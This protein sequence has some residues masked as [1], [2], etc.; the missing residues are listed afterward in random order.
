[1]ETE[2]G[3]ELN[4]IREARCLRLEGMAII[5][6]FSVNRLSKI[7]NGKREIPPGMTDMM[8]KRFRRIGQELTNEEIGALKKAEKEESEWQR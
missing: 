4:A 3:K 6:G 5:L 2:Y 1:M 7:V 8:I